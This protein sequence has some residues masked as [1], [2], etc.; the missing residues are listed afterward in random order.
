MSGQ[1]CGFCFAIAAFLASGAGVLAQDAAGLLR[2]GRELDL[3]GQYGEARDRFRKALDMATTA[4]AKA[5]AQRSLAISYPFEGDCKSAVKFEGPLYET[6]L[7][8][9]SFFEAGET[10]GRPQ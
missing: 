7:A 8:S 6:Y 10:V 5:Q 3:K 1:P 4:Q 2:E 9:K